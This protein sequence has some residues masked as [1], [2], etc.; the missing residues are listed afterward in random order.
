MDDPRKTAEPRMSH[1]PSGGMTCLS[2]ALY[3]LFALAYGAVCVYLMWRF[4][5]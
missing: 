4:P 1:A 5:R 3:I 2:L